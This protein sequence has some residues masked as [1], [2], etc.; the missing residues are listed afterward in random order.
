MS[1]HLYQ[2]ENGCIEGL[3]IYMQSE[4]LWMI[5][6]IIMRIY[7]P[8]ILDHEGGEGGIRTHGGHKG[9]NGFR[10]RPDRP[11]RHLSTQRDDYTK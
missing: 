9:H 10:D 11:L 2:V 8:L 1:R 6:M 5:E 3:F 7:F 4:E